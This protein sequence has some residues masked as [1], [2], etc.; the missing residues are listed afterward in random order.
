MTKRSGKYLILIILLLLSSC[1]SEITRRQEY[2]NKEMD[3]LLIQDLKLNVNE[4]Y[5]WVNLMPGS[6]SRFHI[7][8]DIDLL[9]SI[10]YDFKFV[11][12]ASIIIYQDDIEIYRISPVIREDDSFDTLSKNI[13]FSTI[14][15]L[16]INKD[17]KTDQMIDIDL[18]FNEGSSELIYKLDNLK[19]N[20][21]N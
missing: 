20:T 14:R 11:R 19:I 17:L 2:E 5:S 4:I 7:T 15:G 12:L 21:A 6:D 8:G 1:S 13:K 9:E 16:L 10:K 18:V 3:K